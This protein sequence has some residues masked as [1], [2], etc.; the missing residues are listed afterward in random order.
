MCGIVGI[1]FKNPRDLGISQKN[2]EKLTDEL[3]KGIEPR[4]RDATGLL[5]VD[6]KGV[7][8]LVKADTD[9]STFVNW[10]D[11]I[12][13]RVRTILGHT[14]FATQGTPQ[15]LDNDHPV[16]YRTCYAIHNG[17]I[18]N[19]SVLFQEHSLARHAEVDSEIIPALFDKYGLDKAHLALQELE[20]NYAT[21]VV[22]PDR[23]PNVTILA[24]GW[25]SPIEVLETKHGVIFASTATALQGAC[26][27][28]LGFRP[29]YSK[30]ETLTV[31]D[32]LYME[33][34]TIE[35][36]EF[37]PKSAAR[38]YKPTDYGTGY[39]SGSYSYNPR[40]GAQSSRKFEMLCKSCGCKQLWHGKGSD[41]SGAC[42]TVDDT[43]FAC[44]CIAFVAP[45]VV[46]EHTAW[47]YCDGCNREVLMGNLVKYGRYYLCSDWCAKDLF[48]Q[49]PTSEELRKSAE[50]IVARQVEAADELGVSE[51]ADG[52]WEARLEAHHL[53]SLEM[54]SKSSGMTPAYIDW[55]LF[56]APIDLFEVDGSGYLN[57]AHRIAEEAYDAAFKRLESEL[58]DLD[59]VRWKAGDVILGNACNTAASEDE[60]DACGV[61]VTIEEYQAR[62]E[63]TA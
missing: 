5:T 41:F 63:L 35:R 37:K 40:T 61:I 59:N 10:R 29:A 15:N 6:A 17:H 24:K 31:G 39:S 46:E 62:K 26:E 7:P 53:Q 1:H 9:A 33:G 58:F 18:S 13:R 22:D 36:L 48:V 27:K 8:N 25:S 4:G 52:A 55:L 11:P 56:K 19:D 21:A 20:G 3:L 50:A 34:E 60:G 51:L 54:A 23:F 12:P 43:G 45:P 49:G 38:S 42:T 30:I 14:R 32:L 57:E 47:E 44:R 28:V 2:L 16:Q